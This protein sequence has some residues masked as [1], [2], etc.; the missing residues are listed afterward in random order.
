MKERRIS[1]E[2]RRPVHLDRSRDLGA[3]TPPVE[4]GAGSAEAGDLCV[5][6]TACPSGTRAARPHKAWHGRGYLPYLDQPESIQFVTFRL[7]DSVPAEIVAAW[8][9]ELALTGR[10]PAD[11][12]RCAKLRERIERYSDQGHG[13]CWL[14]DERIAEQVEKTLLHFDGARYRLLAWVV[15]PNHVHALLETLPG[16]PLGGVVHSWKSFSAKQANKLLGRTG[17]F[18]MQDYSDRCIRGEEHFVAAIRYIEQNPV[19]AGLVRSASDWQWGS[20][21]GK[22]AGETPAFLRDTPFPEYPSPLSNPDRTARASR[23]G[24]MESSCAGPV[25]DYPEEWREALIAYLAPSISRLA[26]RGSTLATWT[27]DPEKIRSTFARFAL[28]MVWDFA[29]SCPLADTSGGF[30]QAVE[31]IARVVEHV[32]TATG[33]A[34]APNVLRSSATDLKPGSFDLICTDPPYYDAIPYSDL[35]DF[36]YVWLRRA[37]YGLSPETDAAFAEPLGPKW[38]QE[39]NDGELVD[40]PG[41]FDSDVAASRTAY[42]DGMFRVFQ[43]CLKALNENGRLV[44]VFANKQPS[45]WETLVSAL[46]RAGFVVDGSWPIRTEMQNKVAGGARLSSS[47]WLVCKKRP[48][49]AR[50]GWDGKVLAEMQEHIVERLRDFWDAGIRGPDFVWAATGPVLEA[51]SRHPVVRKADRADER[52]SVAE[53]LCQ[54]R[55]MVVGFVVSRLLQREGGATDELDD[56]ATYY[57]LHRNDFGLGAAPAGACI[58]YA[59]SC[60]LSDADLAGRLGLLARGTRAAPAETRAMTAGGP[61]APEEEGGGAEGNRGRRERGGGARGGGERRLRERGSAQALEPPPRPRSRRAAGGGRRSAADRPRPQADAALEDRRTEPRGRLPGVARALAPRAVRPCRAGPD[62]AGRGRLGGARHPGIHPEPRPHP[63]RRHR[64]P[65]GIPA[66]GADHDP[67]PPGP[68]L[69]L[70]PL[71]G[72]PA[73]PLPRPGRPQRQRQEHK[74]DRYGFHI[75]SERGLLARSPASSGTRRARRFPEPRTPP[76]TSSTVASEK[77]PGRY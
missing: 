61:E 51:F 12:P 66:V 60:N 14:R 42:E 65:P 11:D 28:P 27:N 43:N 1:G 39:E 59:L 77:E 64:P 3:V 31:W 29:E 47:I 69:P 62:R 9:E 71:R 10:E 70:P 45:A 25:G 68:Q 72:R 22:D 2:R 54:V 34:P 55:R 20:V 52:L 26:D 48:A 46:I 16:F 75:K 41:R 57:L 23:A 7:S 19:K 4:P 33:E 24:S 17:P 5:L 49:T 63:R 44:V 13:A 18:W 74:E 50:P 58:L 35:M 76:A 56:P 40:Q 21:S 32:Q 15:M 53:F 6:G 8:K 36:F 37:L 67:S 30:I 38:D 73:R